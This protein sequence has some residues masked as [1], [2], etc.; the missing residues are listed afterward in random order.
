MLTGIDVVALNLRRH[1]ECTR[2]DV[3]VSGRR[4]QNSRQLQIRRAAASKKGIGVT[5]D[6]RKGGKAA[7]DVD[8][9]EEDEE[10]DIFNLDAP[11]DSEY[12]GPVKGSFSFT[13]YIRRNKYER[14]RCWL[15]PC[16]SAEG[17]APLQ[18]T[19]GVSMIWRM[20]KMSGQ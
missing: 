14:F 5:Y 11:E 15:G 17:H 1:G 10:V 18:I 9:E 6:P 7:W 13:F 20:M 12:S 4:A 3:G 8:D 16:P 2:K 19:A